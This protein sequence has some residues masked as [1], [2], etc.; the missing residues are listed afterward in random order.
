MLAKNSQ[1]ILSSLSKNISGQARLI[2][3]G[4]NV[5]N[6]P[7]AGE[8]KVKPEQKAKKVGI[9]IFHKISK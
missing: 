3:Q 1:K 5:T 8:P 2:S 9:Y 6:A 4:Q 7:A